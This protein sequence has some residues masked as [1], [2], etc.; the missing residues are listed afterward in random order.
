[1]SQHPNTPSPASFNPFTVL[2]GNI[3]TGHASL[4]ARRRRQRKHNIHDLNGEVEHHDE[5]STTSSTSSKHVSAGRAEHCSPYEGFSNYRRQSVDHFKANMREELSSMPLFGLNPDLRP[6]Q[7][8]PDPIQTTMTRYSLSQLAP[9]INFDFDHSDR[10]ANA[11]RDLPAYFNRLFAAPASMFGPMLE[12]PL[13]DKAS[14]CPCARSA[15]GNDKSCLA[16]DKDHHEDTSSDVYDDVTDQVSGDD[17]PD[18]LVPTSDDD[19]DISDL[20]SASDDLDEFREAQLRILA[21][22]SMPHASP[23]SNNTPN[24]SSSSLDM[25]KATME[26]YATAAAT[27]ADQPSHSRRPTTP[28][29]SSVSVHLAIKDAGTT[30]VF[31]MSANERDVTQQL[32]HMKRCAEHLLEKIEEHGAQLDYQTVLDVL[33][34]EG[35]AKEALNEDAGRA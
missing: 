19:D 31:N 3:E 27:L 5:T 35:A 11:Q 1:M 24:T 9:T 18:D 10:P 7:E 34:W 13:E 30:H 33:A 22:G 8:P 12:K 29:S 14:M 4:K 2:E 25:Y 6:R 21:P 23:S 15:S 28:D 16:S 32:R 17:T 20:V 26:R